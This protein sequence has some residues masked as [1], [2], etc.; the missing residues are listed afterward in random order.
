MLNALRLHEP[1]L[2]SHF[3]ASTGLHRKVLE[4]QLLLLEKQELIAVNSNG[5]ELTARGLQFA[6]DAVMEF[7]ELR[8]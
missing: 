8:D 1:I 7:M 6:D 3:E 2:F 5:F 4:Q